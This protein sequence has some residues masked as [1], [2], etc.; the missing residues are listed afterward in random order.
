MAKR[1]HSNLLD[2]PNI[3]HLYL[4]YDSEQREIFKFGISDNAV[5]EDYSSTR[6]DYQLALF[7]R[8]AGW[9]RFIGRILAHPI[10]G[11][12]NARQLEDEAIL[13]F[14]KKYGRFPRGNPNHQFLKT[15]K[16]NLA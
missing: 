15:D 6:I 14:Q 12:L 11:R 2:N 9:K 13:K 1:R 4:I 3:H 10:K 5:N 16:G 8:I 7:N